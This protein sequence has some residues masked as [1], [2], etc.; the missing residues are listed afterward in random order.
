M[1][2]HRTIH[3]CKVSTEAHCRRILQSSWT[4]MADGHA[5]E[6]CLELPVIAPVSTAVREVVEGCAELGVS[7]LTLYA[8]SVENWKRPAT[9][10]RTLMLLLQRVPEP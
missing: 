10:V 6:A 9:E 2:G 1:L 3:C 7:V 5:R 4:A 8:F